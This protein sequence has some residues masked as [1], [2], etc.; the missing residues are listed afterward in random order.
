MVDNFLKDQ[1]TI[2]TNNNN[3]DVSSYLDLTKRALFKYLWRS[4][5]KL[6]VECMEA[7][8]LLMSTTCRDL[9]FYNMAH[10]L[11]LAQEKA[12][13]TVGEMVGV[14]AAQSISE[15]FTQGLLNSFHH[16][17]TKICG[18]VSGLQRILDIFDAIKKVKT[19]FMEPLPE[20]AY[21]INLSNACSSA[22]LSYE[23]GS[24]MFCFNGV[25]TLDEFSFTKTLVATMK[26]RSGGCSGT[27]ASYNNELLKV[28]LD[29]SDVMEFYDAAKLL[30]SVMDENI[31]GLPHAIDSSE[32]FAAY[33]TGQHRVYFDSTGLQ[34]DLGY[35]VD[36]FGDNVALKVRS[37][38]IRWMETNL[39]IE[40]TLSYLVNEIQDT[41]CKEGIEVNIRH[42]QLV[43]EH[44]ASTGKVAA[45]R[46]VSVDIM[47][48]V[49]RKATFEQGS[50]TLCLAASSGAE[51]TI[52]CPSSC[53]LMGKLM[54]IGP[55]N[56]DLVGAV[57]EQIHPV[58]SQSTMAKDIARV[59]SPSSSSS[60]N[61][62]YS[63]AMVY[64]PASPSAAA[65]VEESDVTMTTQVQ[66]KNIEYNAM[67]ID[68][69]L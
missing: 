30:D 29:K 31:D 59:T 19:P 6:L 9:S 1:P 45:N 18:V 47:E 55:V 37:S 17:G 5:N 46:Y 66:P 67:D 63:P 34:F 57:V 25:A 60:S 27:K 2:M 54:E 52:N 58:K 48:G 22:Y 20:S 50:R 56:V 13:I 15:R 39:G 38:D 43:V 21:G 53:V 68:D 64:I 28:S 14:I 42:I 16:S 35:L 12:R 69:L 8:A 7:C 10:N 49:F 33:G 3:S 61:S 51:D 65:N 26:T 4:A 11:D 24:K 44:M 36:N 32:V 41:L 40:A 23:N 62:S